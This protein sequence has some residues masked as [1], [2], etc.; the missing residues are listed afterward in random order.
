MP[1]M[2]EDA[3]LVKQAGLLEFY[4]SKSEHVFLVSTPG[5]QSGPARLARADLMGLLDIFDQQTQEKEAQLLEEL[6]CDEDDF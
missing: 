4:F 5:C 2:P 6:E 1:A 3:I